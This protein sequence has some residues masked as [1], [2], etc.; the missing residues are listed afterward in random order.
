M[1]CSNG[2]DWKIRAVHLG[3]V[4]F[5]AGGPHGAADRVTALRLAAV[6]E[7]C[8]LVFGNYR[9]I[10]AF[11]WRTLVICVALVAILS[12]VLSK[13]GFEYG[14]LYADRGASL[15]LAVAIVGLLL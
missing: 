5:A 10:W 1:P 14:I 4:L 3:A 9:G 2:R 13:R 8:R 15:S 6:L 7:I 11:I 12:V